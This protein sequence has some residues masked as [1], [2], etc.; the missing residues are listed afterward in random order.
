MN[1]VLSV[2]QQIE[3]YGTTCIAKAMGLPI[4][5]I[6]TWKKANAIPGSGLLHDMKV[7]A[8]KA[9][10]KSLKKAAKKQRKAA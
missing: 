7:Q 3:M 8:F 10:V 4:S 5:T 1:N 9:A 6:H 2:A